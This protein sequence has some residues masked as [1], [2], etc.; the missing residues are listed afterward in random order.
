M[1]AAPGARSSATTPAR[2]A[3]RDP[4][5]LA[6]ALGLPRNP[7]AARR[8]VRLRPPARARRFRV[9][10]TAA[11]LLNRRAPGRVSRGDPVVPVRAPH[12]SPSLRRHHLRELAGRRE[13]WTAACATSGL[14]VARFP[15][16]SHEPALES[17]STATPLALVGNSAHVSALPSQ[18]RSDEVGSDSLLH[19]ATSSQEAG[20]PFLSPPISFSSTSSR[21]SRSVSRHSPVLLRCLRTT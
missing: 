2:G 5:P 6:R 21:G 10:R 13:N 16:S 19:T 11:T 20:E 4:L 9:S 1:S 3:R 8:R 17:P 14:V 12:L 18:P 15:S 7:A